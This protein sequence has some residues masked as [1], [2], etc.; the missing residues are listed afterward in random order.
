MFGFGKRNALIRELLEQ[1]M[2]A[3]GFDDMESRLKVKELGSFKL[4]ASPEGTIVGIVEIVINQQRNG[5]LLADIIKKIENKRRRIG[6]M[7]L[8][9]NELLQLAIG[10]NP[11]LAVFEFCA[12][13]IEVE[14]YG[15][16]TKE[17]VYEAVDKATQIIATW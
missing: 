1:R 3:A 10:P 8:E 12:Y 11:S 16:M 7:P 17:Q 13:R 15:V 9:F 6:G 14:H 4:L 2:R 5:V